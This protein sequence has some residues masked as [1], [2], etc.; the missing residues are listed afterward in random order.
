MHE[1]SIYS[2]WQNLRTKPSITLACPLPTVGY[3]LPGTCLQACSAK[4]ADRLLLAGNEVPSPSSSKQ[5]G[6]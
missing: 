3:L 2:V 5:S 1:N 6:K 4:I